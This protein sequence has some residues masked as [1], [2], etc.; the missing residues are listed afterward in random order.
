VGNVGGEYDYWLLKGN[1]YF[2]AGG[3]PSNPILFGSVL[4]TLFKLLV[5]AYRNPLMIL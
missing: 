2:T 4:N 3:F 5:A 1:E